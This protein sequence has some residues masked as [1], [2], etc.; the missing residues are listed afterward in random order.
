M[1]EHEER[2]AKMGIESFLTASS[3]CSAARSGYCIAT[4]AIPTKRSG[5]DA[6]Y[7]EIFSF[8][9]FTTSRARPRSA[10]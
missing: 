7:C 10:L 5:C 9:S 1:S 3:S 8:C 6:Q 2:L 4:V